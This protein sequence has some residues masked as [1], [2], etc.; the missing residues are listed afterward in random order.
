[1]PCKR[2]LDNE[3]RQQLHTLAYNLANFLRRM[4]PPAGKA[5]WSLTSLL[6]K[7]VKAGARTVR[8]AR[9]IALQPAGLGLQGRNGQGCPCRHSQIASATIG[10][11]TASQIQAEQDG[12]DRSFQDAEKPS[13]RVS[14]A[15][16]VR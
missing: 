1:M 13:C 9:A 3:I 6:L 15:D 2:F 11:V 16:T 8:H 12:L 7:L 14:G 5:E 10:R 4:K